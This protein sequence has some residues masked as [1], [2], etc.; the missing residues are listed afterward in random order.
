MR[1]FQINLCELPIRELLPVQGDAQV[2]IVKESIISYF[3]EV[4][5]AQDILNILKQSS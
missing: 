1:L 2:I 3:L 5:K 4:D